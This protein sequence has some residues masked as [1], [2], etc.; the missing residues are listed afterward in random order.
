MVE[1]RGLVGDMF[2]ILNPMADYSTEDGGYKTYAKVSII[3]GH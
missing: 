2:G 1:G 3:H